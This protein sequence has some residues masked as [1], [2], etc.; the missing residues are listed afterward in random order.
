MKYRPDFESA[1]NDLAN[2]VADDLGLAHDELLPTPA[3][4]AGILGEDWMVRAR[5]KYQLQFS[6]LYDLVKEEYPEDRSALF[7]QSDSPVDPPTIWHDLSM[8]YGLRIEGLPVSEMLMNADG[9]IDRRLTAGLQT[10]HLV[11]LFV[12]PEEIIRPVGAGDDQPVGAEDNLTAGFEAVDMIWQSADTTQRTDLEHP[13]KPLIA[14]W[15]NRPEVIQPDL[16]KGGRPRTQGIMPDGLFSGQPYSIP[17]QLRSDNGG[18]QF[19]NL[20]KMERDG[21]QLPLLADILD[22]ADLPIAPLL[23]AKAAGFHGLQPG[24]GARLDKRILIFS[25]LEMP[26]NQR[27]PGGRYELRRPL[28]FW[29]DLLWPTREGKSSYRPIKHKQALRDALTAINLAEIIMPDGSSWIPVVRRGIPDLDSLDSEVIIQIELPSGSD[30]GP[31]V[32]KGVLAVAGVVSDPAFDLELGLAYLWDE[33]KR[34]NGG[35]RIYATRPEV[36]R[37]KQGHILDPADQVIV[38]GGKPATRWDHPRAVRTGRMERNPAADRVR[39]LDRE[40]RRRL[41]Y[42]SGNSKRPDQLSRERAATDKRLAGIESDGRV[43][44]ERD[45]IDLRNGGDGWRIL[46]VWTPDA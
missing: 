6:N 46:E 10:L 21:E 30:R 36:I 27:R 33:A 3:D 9:E 11:V 5:K 45:A 15:L 14:G 22:D 20:G 8:D 42:G 19:P 32:D 17:A 40:A 35:Y 12:G 34:R 41:A 4:V 16:D 29:R 38:E 1:W 28:R 18:E 43:L 26:L 31:Q 7:P 13:L 39:V 23:L 24:R 25:L 2:K 37:N 44:I